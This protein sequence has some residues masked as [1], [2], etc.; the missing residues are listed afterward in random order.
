MYAG[1]PPDV[2][3]GKD[4]EKSEMTQVR[5]DGRRAAQSV[6]A[7][8]VAGTLCW[9]AYFLAVSPDQIDLRLRLD[10]EATLGS[11][12][13]IAFMPVV[14][15]LCYVILRL[16][17]KMGMVNTPYREP[18]APEEASRIAAN[19]NL[20]TMLIFVAVIVGM[21]SGRSWPPGR[22]AT[23]LLSVTLMVTVVVLAYR[24]LSSRWSKQSS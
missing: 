15:A 17:E 23:T 5:T 14:M 18:V 21:V 19:L 6:A 11:K 24:L 16:A 3:V 9:T 7:I 2:D 8:I 12:W 4:G 10:E 22:V 20:L 1:R 13:R